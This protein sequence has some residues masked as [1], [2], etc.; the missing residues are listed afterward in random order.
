VCGRYTLTTPDP[1]MLRS[2]FALGEAVQVERRYNVAPGDEVLAVVAGDH[3]AVG[4]R[5]RW[6]LVPQWAGDGDAGL[7][8]I[9]ARAETVRS[10]PAFRSAFARRRCLI[11]ADGFYEWRRSGD[12]GPR[13]PKQ[14]YWITRADGAPFAFAGLW[15]SART[16]QG[17]TLRSCAIVTTAANR[18]LEP[19]H[20]RMP[21]MLG[22]EA[23]SAWIAST[24]GA[25]KLDALLRPLPDD[26]TAMRPVGTAVNDARYDGP[27][28]LE[29]PRPVTAPQAAPR[30]F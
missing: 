19:I 9:N 15:A 12:Q 26:Q 23:E 6:G 2:R 1:G 14:A 8:M 25:G 11:V 3:G 7:K 5:L 4:A 30:L 17:E 16:P 22:A 27:E 24:S 20:D 21:V 28:C 29:A 13:A 18:T 10:K